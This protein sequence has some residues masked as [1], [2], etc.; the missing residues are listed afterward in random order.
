MR[1]QR[2]GEELLLSPMCLTAW[3]APIDNE[4]RVKE[5]WGHFNTWKGENL[6]RIFN[7]IHEIKRTG[8]VI[9]VDGVLA[10]V[11]RAPFFKYILEFHFYND[12]KVHI[13]LSGKIR[14][15]CIWLQRL[16]FEFTTPGEKDSF[17]YYG[18]GPLENYCDM[19]LHT[20]TGIFESTAD[21]EYFPSIMP[22][23]HGN[24]TECKLLIQKDGLE[25]TAETKFEI[26]VSKYSTEALTEAMHIDELV[27][28]GAVHIRVDYKDSGV[29]SNSCGPALME[30][31]RLTE[32]DIVFSFVMG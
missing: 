19:Y 25:F 15:N 18:R 10:G 4:R 24:H 1:M 7:N 13:K 26:N 30:K 22:Q 6:D 5:K 31:Y 21:K 27:A 12:G 17:R 16:G 9:S 28:D 14:E 11:G 32:K 3:R 8:T 20:T 23:E 29:G 2:G